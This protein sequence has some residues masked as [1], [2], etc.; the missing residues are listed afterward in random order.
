M[1]E[2]RWLS[3][4]I[5]LLFFSGTANSQEVI[6]VSGKVR[7]ENGNP[8]IGVNIIE[9]GTMNG[10]VTDVN[11]IYSLDVSGPEATLVFSFIGYVKKEKIVSGQEEINIT[12]EPDLQELDEIVVVGYGTV[13]K[14]D[15]TGSVELIGA[16]SINK[17]PLR[18][19]EQVLQGQASGVFVAA[20]SGAPGSPVSVRIRGVGTPSNTDPLYI[21]DGMPI[22]DASFGKNDNP[23]G[24]NFLNPADIESIQ[25]LK[26]A[27]ATAIYGTRG[28]NGVIIITT[29]KGQSGKPKIDFH[30]YA[31]F[32]ELPDKLDV[33]NAQQFATLYNEAMGDYY[34]S[35][36]IPMLQTTDWQDEV[37]T[38]APTN[39][40]QLSVSGG[41]DKATYYLSFNNFSQDGIV[42]QS[43]YN[44]HSFRINS[45]Y[46]INNWL[47]IGQHMTLTHFLNQ[48][49]RET[50]L[51]SGATVGNPIIGALKANPTI[52]PRDEEGNLNYIDLTN[53]SSTVNPVGLIERRHYKYNNNRIQ[54]IV[55][56]ELE[57]IKNLFLKF[58][59]G[60][61]RSWGY[62]KEVWPE[63]EV[64]NE[65]ASENTLLITEH[66]TWYNYLL[67]STMQ[68]NIEIGDNQSFT[69]LAGLTRQEEVKSPNVASSYLPSPQDEML[70]H[71]ARASIGE[72]V[73]LGG[74]PIE[75]SLLSYLGRINYSYQGKYLLTASVR[76]DGS[77]RF[78]PNSRYGTFPSFAL[79]W[80]LSQEPFMSGMSNLTMLKLRGGWGIVGNQNIEPYL[81][82]AKITFQPD[83]GL[84]GPIVFYGSPAKAYPA[85]FFDGIANPNIGWETTETY[86]LGIDLSLWDNRISSTIDVYDKTTT[87]ILLF[88]PVPLWA[89]ADAKVIKSGQIKNTGVVNNKGLDVLLMYKQ[90]VNDFYFEVGGNFS[91]L[92][93]EVIDMEDGVPLSSDTDFPV[94]MIEGKPIGAFYGYVTEGIF[95]SEEEIQNHALQE[96]RTGVGDLKFK[97]LNLD[98]VIDDADQ[99]TLG[100]ALPDFNYGINLN[101]SYKNLSLDI[102]TQGVRGNSIANMVKRLALYNL[103]MTSNVSTDLLNA[104]GREKE[105]G[106]IITDTNIPRIVG[107]RDNNDNDRISDFYLEDGSYFRIKNIVLTYQIPE[108]ITQLL[109]LSHFSI[110]GTIQNLHTFTNYSGYNPEIGVSS[111]FNANPLAFGIDNA[112]YPMPRTIM[113]GINIGL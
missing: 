34:D 89:G 16:E 65:D 99:T 97:D 33:L 41:S 49:Q 87:D 3:I 29:K 15:L 100:Y 64:A 113:A 11:G 46:Q 2:S 6:S 112:V 84:P 80:R 30:A 17:L 35:D 81:Y 48:R 45:D 111:A 5:L 23:S 58:N 85:A 54:G 73:Q 52:A 74:S 40:E 60:L 8:L 18:S 66:E 26:D 105:D 37:Y 106:S 27:S 71:S 51:N 43:Y 39:S 75:W 21:V 12:L 70:Y 1:M 32:Q 76:R 47:K 28:A 55:F 110:Y 68:Y 44:R 104:Y 108:N 78:G 50:G 4:L 19:T 88:N 91:Y 96:R 107:R 95:K 93:N 101:L 103:R 9:K 13:K 77:S 10:T 63:Y 42:K 90:S 25:V 109:G 24:I 38:L 31:G 20:S 82:R 57:P 22:K 53:A 7:D 94:R 98:G 79:G 61:D 72:T 92:I 59:G 69:F 14:K 62:R 67:E 86:N 83:Q 36:S 102:L 56:M